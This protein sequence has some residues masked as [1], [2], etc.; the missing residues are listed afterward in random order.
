MEG[1]GLKKLLFVC[2]GNTC[3]SPLAE[4]IAKQIFPGTVSHGIEVSS[5]GTSAA[6]GLP[7][8]GLAVEVAGENGIDLSG[9][10]S[11]HLDRE[12][13]GA[14]DLIVAMT[15][16]HREIVGTIEPSS[17]AY[18]YVLSDFCGG[19]PGDIPDP[20]ASGLEIYRETFKT[21]KECIDAL[22]DRMDAF[23]GWKQ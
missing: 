10:R 21:I 9:H 6:D 7:A 14:A 15:R 18:T 8:S 5:A 20:I 17:L 4:G 13:I 19:V 2:S 23:D 11:R 16:R 22:A 3:R 1:L 12:L